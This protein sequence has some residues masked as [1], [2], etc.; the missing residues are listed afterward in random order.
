MQTTNKR[1]DIERA[2]A[3]LRRH[4]WA[5]SGEEPAPP[6][7]QQALAPEAACDTGSMLAEEID[8]AGWPALVAPFY[9]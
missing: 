6:L 7:A 8:V 3:W 2:A 1:W 4:G 5:D 9:D